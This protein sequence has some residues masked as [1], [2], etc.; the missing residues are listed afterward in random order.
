MG[1]A[2]GSYPLDFGL[3]TIG[4]DEFAAF[5]DGVL[6]V[7]ATEVV[8]GGLRRRHV[9]QPGVPI[10]NFVGRVDDNDVPRLIEAQ[11]VKPVEMVFEIDG[12][13]FSWRPIIKGEGPDVIVINYRHGPKPIEPN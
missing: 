3:R 13:Q 9:P 4:E 2:P 8:P 11:R 10:Y 6:Q 7:V 5:G 1:F 12:Q